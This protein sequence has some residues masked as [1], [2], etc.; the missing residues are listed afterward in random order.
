M[1]VWRYGIVII[2][3]IGIILYCVG[4]L[5]SPLFSILYTLYGTGSSTLHALF[6]TLSIIIYIPIYVFMEGFFPLFL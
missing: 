2:E 3:E 6:K 5:K 4:D 1:L